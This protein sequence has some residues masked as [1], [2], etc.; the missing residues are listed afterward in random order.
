MGKQSAAETQFR[1]RVQR[2]RKRRKWSRAD[3][4]KRLQDKGLEHLYASTVAK[5]EYGERPV[6]IDE[7]T[8]IA[9]LFEVSVDTLLGRSV[10]PKNDKMY[11]FKALLDSAQQASWQVSSIESTLRDQTA[12]LA[13]FDLPKMMKAFQSDCE[14]ACDALAQANDALRD[15]GNPSGS[16]ELQRLTRKLLLRELQKE[17][18]EDE[19]QS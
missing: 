3:L 16:G 13:A 10:A 17:E 7:A 15:A 6:R 19:A 14:R 5:I 9:D 4:S 1:E 11:V 8:A 2:E 12:E 18:R